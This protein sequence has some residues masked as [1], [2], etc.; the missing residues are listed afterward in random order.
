MILLVF[1]FSIGLFNTDTK[2]KYY[3]Y[4]ILLLMQR[5]IDFLMRIF[6]P[7]GGM[8]SQYTSPYLVCIAQKK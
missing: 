4:R 1:I 7:Q 3:I 8:V 5:P 2:W 6:F